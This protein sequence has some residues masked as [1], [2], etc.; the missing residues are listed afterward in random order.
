MTVMAMASI[1]ISTVSENEVVALNSDDDD[2]A[3]H[4]DGGDE[5][6][7]YDDEDEESLHGSE[8]E[9]ENKVDLLDNEDEDHVW[10]DIEL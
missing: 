1:L 4:F 2:E 9:S 8:D 6:P 3:M 5:G 7:C 10:I